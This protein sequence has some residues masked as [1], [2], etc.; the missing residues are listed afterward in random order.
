MCVQHLSLQVHLFVD[1][2]I[3]CVLISTFFIFSLWRLAWNVESITAQHALPN[4]TSRGRYAS[5]V[6]YHINLAARRT[7]LKIGKLLF[8]GNVCIMCHTNIILVHGKTVIRHLLRRQLLRRQLLLRW[9]LKQQRVR[10]R[11]MIGFLVWGR[12]R[13]KIR[14]RVWVRVRVKVG[15]T[16]NV[17][18]YHWSNC[19]QSKCRTFGKTVRFCPKNVRGKRDKDNKSHKRSSC[20]NHDFSQMTFSGPVLSV[21]LLGS[22]EMCVVAYM[23]P[24]DS[25]GTW[26]KWKLIYIFF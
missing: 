9:Y 17:R 14:I 25:F 13:I 24:M 3:Y 18:V 11:V 19:R 22:V 12:V 23:K 4:S 5:I 2:N 16:F 6:P 8:C 1:Y 7:H 15:V 20:K 21:L 10:V 26:R